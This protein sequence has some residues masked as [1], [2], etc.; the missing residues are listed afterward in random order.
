MESKTMNL[1][2][3]KSLSLSLP[4]PPSPLLSCSFLPPFFPP[5]LHLFFLPIFINYFLMSPFFPV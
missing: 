5:S 1:S 4:Y 3:V 2:T